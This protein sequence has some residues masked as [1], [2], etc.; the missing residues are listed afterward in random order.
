MRILLTGATGLV[1]QGVLKVCL[2]DPRV[3]GITALGRH[4][5]GST[6]DK[7]EDLVVAD[8]GDLSAV[9]DRLHPFD[10]CLYCAGAI[11][12]G[13][14][15]AEYRRVTL[16]LT[17][18]VA[19]T[20]AR[21]NP[22]LTFVYVSGAHSNPDSAIMPLRV[23]GE[24]ERALAALPL[25]TIM[26]RTGGIQPSQGERS[27]HPAMAAFYSVAA[28]V[29]GVGVRW[30]PGVLTSTDRVGKAM[31]QLLRQ[32]DPPAIV[33]NDAINALAEAYDAS[34]PGQGQG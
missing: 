19:Q 5:S 23:K 8:F 30:M 1:G 7:V 3:T 17:L 31:L 13:M 16:E 15:E 22:A 6:H 9:E 21:S 20:L 34:T 12:L 2:E 24:T 10:A 27:P 28:P 11:P 4:A 26:L 14:A 33:E 18:N 32:P 29:M 25:R